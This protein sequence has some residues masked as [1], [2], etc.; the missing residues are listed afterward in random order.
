MIPP[1]SYPLL[2]FNDGQD[3]DALDMIGSSLEEQLAID[4]E[5]AFIVAGMYANE[6]RIYE[7]GTAIQ[8]DYAGRGS[9]AAATTSFLLHELLPFLKSHYQHQTHRTLPTRDFLWEV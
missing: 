5:N 8:S 1:D 6:D 4:P 3:F 9:K 2:L 7:Y